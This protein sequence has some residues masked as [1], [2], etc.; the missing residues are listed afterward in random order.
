MSAAE[1]AT[2]AE[3]GA[4]APAVEETPQNGDAKKNGGKNFKRD[5]TPI[6]DLFDLSQPIPK[7]R[8]TVRRLYVTSDSW[9]SLFS[10]CVYLL[11]SRRI[12]PT[13]LSTIRTSRS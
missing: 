8:N 5:E 2:T 11:H 10:H 3:A 9:Q 6:E 1:E 7:V 13:R 4:A 12:D